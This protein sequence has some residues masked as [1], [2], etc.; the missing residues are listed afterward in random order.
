MTPAPID[1]ELAAQLS[2][3]ALRAYDVIGAAGLARVDFI[4]D[5][6][7]SFYCLELNTLPGMT[8]LS[9]SPMAAGAAGIS[10]DQLVDRI[11][12]SALK[13]RLR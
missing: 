5:E 8:E 3:A 12:R 2:D 10:F 4:L 7:E 9:L 6:N 11:V 1:P 13:G